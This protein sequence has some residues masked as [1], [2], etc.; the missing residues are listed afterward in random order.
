[1]TPPSVHLFFAAICLEHNIIFYQQVP[2][3]DF[4]M[5]RP[6]SP[7]NSVNIASDMQWILFQSYHI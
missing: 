2:H 5:S 6:P 3:Q 1:M 7:Y 4:S